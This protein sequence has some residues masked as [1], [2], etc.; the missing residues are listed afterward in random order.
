MA[1]RTDKPFNVKCE[2]PGEAAVLRDTL[3][4]LL[5]QW[6]PDVVNERG[7]PF[8]PAGTSH[9]GWVDAIRGSMLDHG[10]RMYG[11]VWNHNPTRCVVYWANT[12]LPAHPT[13]SLQE[14]LSMVVPNRD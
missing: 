5:D 14:F 8:S 10:G 4:S 2:T 7:S 13:Y 9:P 12:L 3:S 6:Y 1:L 11:R